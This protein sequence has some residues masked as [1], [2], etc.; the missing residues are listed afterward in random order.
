MIDGLQPYPAMKESGVAWLGEVP[1]HWEVRKLKNWLAINELVLSEDTNPD[2]AFHY[3]DIGCVS[4]GHIV[5]CPERIQFKSAPSR[6][7]RIVRPGDTVI[8]TVRTYLKAVWH[9]EGPNPDLIASTGF[10]VLTPKSGTCPKYVSY[11]CQ[12]ESFTDR[13]TAQSVGVAYPAIAESRLATFHISVPPLSEQ[14]AIVRFLDHFDRRI[15]RYIRAREKLIALLEEQKQA[16]IHQAVTGQID[17]RTGQPY[18][19]YKPSGVEWLG[20]VPAHWQVVRNGRLFVQRNEIGFAGLPILEV[21]LRTGVRVRDMESSGRKQVMSDRNMYKRAVKGDIAYNMMRMW[22]GAVGTTPVDGLVSPAYVVAKPLA[23]TEPRYFSDLFQTTAYMSEVDK[24]SRGI[25]KDR[26]RLYWEDFKQM[27]TPCPRWSE[28][29]LIADAID[30]GMATIDQRIRLAERQIDLL[31]EYR[32]RLISDVV[33]GKLDV[34]DA[35]AALPE[36]PGAPLAPEGERAGPGGRDEGRTSP[37]RRI[38]FPAAQ[39]EVTL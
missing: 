34:R 38:E 19:A 25:V 31:R 12:S 5:V 30:H 7:R 3:L 10:A 27:P 32:T 4:T 33:T 28:Q 39:E 8:S 17:V 14:A 29:I 20:D 24:F 1:E 37:S 2:Y 13:V 23:G 26:N 35:A 21:S 16:V 11:L 36:E 18:P 22:Q 6:A 9:V 15:R